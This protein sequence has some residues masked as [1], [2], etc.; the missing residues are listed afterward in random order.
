MATLAVTNTF[1]AGTTIVASEMNT[2]FDDIEAF[3]NTTPGVVQ[4]DIVDAKGDIVAASAADTVSRLAVG[5]DT[6]V[7]TADSGEATGL[8]WAAPTTGDVTGV[9]AGTNIDVASASGPVPSV[10]L[11]IDAAVD[12]GVDGTGVDMTFHSSTAGDYMLWDASEEKLIIEGTNGATALDVTDG[13]V[14]IGDGTLVVGSDGAGEDVTFHSGTAG[15]YLL[16][17]SSEEK[18]ILEGTNGATVLDITDGNVV[19]GDGTLVV[20]SDGAGEDV[21]FH[22]DTAG[23][24]FV[25]D[26]SEEK[27][28]ITGT[29]GQTALDVPDGNVTITDALTV[30]GGIT[31]PITIN[32]ET[33]S[34]TLVA[35]DAGGIV[36]MNDGSANNLTIPPNSSV[37]F[38]TGT[39]IIIVQQGAGATTIVEG[40][41]VTT[42]SL[43]DNAIINGQYVSVAL[44]KRDTD[45][46]YIFGNLTS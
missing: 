1:S 43:D 38:A 35:G 8:K 10:A 45:E 21:T 30:S 14:V 20:G 12:V 28:T 34:Y 33:A 18:L 26:S 3:V 24:A 15:D 27:L 31:A 32:N 11:A 2:N 4:V 16:W 41:G 5:T 19:I 29:D 44:V 39:Q 25:W 6:Y 13:N 7:L 9:A 40:S 42:R 36:E 23:D 37:A 46:W 22:S 17:D